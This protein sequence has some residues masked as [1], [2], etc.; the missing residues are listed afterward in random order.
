MEVIRKV[1]D[2]WIEVDTADVVTTTY[3]MEMLNREKVM[4]EERLAS[5]ND[6]LK[7]FDAVKGEEI[8]L[9]A[10]TIEEVATTIARRIDDKGTGV[11]ITD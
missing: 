11:A 2:V 10:T 9:K 1:S 6:I 8:N 4:L 3:D 7:K 5:I